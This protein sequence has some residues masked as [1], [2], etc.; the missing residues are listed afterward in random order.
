MSDIL[1]IKSIA[2]FHEILGLPSPNHP[3]ISLIQDSDVKN[4]EFDDDL[5]DIRFSSSM[6][7]IMFKDKISGSLGYGRNSYDYQ[8][9]TLIFAN[10][11]QVF[12][13]PKKED[14]KG[15]EGWTL[16]FHPD[17]LLKSNMYNQMESYTF[18][19]YEVNEALHLSKREE[20]YIT[21]IIDQIRSEYSQ[22]IDKH[23]QNLILSN[24]E[25]FLNYCMRFYDRQFYTRTNLNTDLVG[26][27]RS[28]LKAY[29]KSEQIVK[30]GLP[31]SNYFGKM[32]N[33]SP[34]YLSDLLKK[35]TGIGIKEHIDA[36][37][38]KKAKNILLSSNQTVGEI[39]FTLGF[40]YPQSFTRMF[41]KKTGYSPNEYRA[42]N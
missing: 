17:L 14:L 25:L 30:K 16:L 7:T 13:T 34:N 8:E 35:E 15:K 6:Y 32:L 3:L 41:K 24:L 27:F 31:S 19:D 20:D 23:S 18:F 12:T 2:Q 42:M 29:F 40:E 21:N 33:M 22:N 37:V 10:P 36:Y 4:L 9:G 28:K 1:R 26:D 11:N 38:V 39:A 5:F